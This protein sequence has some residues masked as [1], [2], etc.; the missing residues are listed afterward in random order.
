VANKEDASHSGSDKLKPFYG[1]DAATMK[2]ILDNSYDEIFVLDRNDRVI[3]VNNVCER[4]YG[5]KASEV[6]GQTLT[7]LSR[8]GYWHPLIT[9][10]VHKEK[11][12]VT[13]EQTT[14][15][16]KKLITTVTPVFDEKGEIEMTVHNARDLTQLE[17]IKREL[18][19]TRDELTHK[20][21]R[22]SASCKVF[23]EIIF[24]GQDM[25][26]LVEF[27]ERVA[28][29]DSTVLISGESGT[30]KGLF[31]RHIH[32]FSRRK[33]GPFLAINCAAIPENLLESELF[34]YANGAFTGADHKGKKGLIELAIGGTLFLDEITELSPHLQ[35]K[36]LQVIQERQFIPVGGTE[37]KSADIRIISATNCNLQE[38]VKN[39][40]FRKDLYYRL[41]VI[42]INIP[43]L[44]ERPE[45]I[46]PLVY[47]SLEKCNKKYSVSRDISKK[48]LD[49]LC[50]YSWPGN[51]RELENLMERLVVTVREHEI[52]AHHLPDLFRQ[53]N[54]TTGKV[55]LNFDTSRLSINRS[56]KETMDE[57]EKEL[58]VMAYRKFASSRK[59]AEAL[60]LSQTK[61]SRLIRKYCT[62]ELS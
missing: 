37:F 15:L 1:L 39:G 18:E 12:R 33:D 10:L 42:E 50:G 48:A 14:Y 19:K 3:Y 30:G 27:A 49:I 60:K 47:Y 41:N 46:I 52:K 35:A 5:M 11:R 45:D 40:K 25:R 4:H 56:F 62:R 21:K 53:E 29:V 23:C 32:K 54:S 22:D 51:V 43:P 57:V 59:V 38:M 2:K 24:Q 28:T 16:G 26:N 61:A 8:L 58:V 17:G 34:G 13:M 44:R 36:I 9:P 55:L 6:I 20:G 31:A 7:K